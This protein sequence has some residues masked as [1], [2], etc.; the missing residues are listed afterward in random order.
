MVL[1]DDALHDIQ[2]DARAGFVTLGL[3]EGLE[4]ALAIFLADANAIIA[5]ADAEPLAVGVFDTLQTDFILRILVGIGE[6]VAD[7]LDDGLL[8]HD[9]REVLTGVIN[10]ELLAILFEGGNKAFA[11]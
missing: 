11:H 7:G 4:D 3:E 9:S 6:Q 2:S 10:G 5:H 8:V 1:I